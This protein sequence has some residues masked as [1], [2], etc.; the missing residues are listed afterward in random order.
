MLLSS[1]PWLLFVTFLQPWIKAFVIIITLS[2]SSAFGSYLSLLH[3]IFP[4]T[5]VTTFPLKKMQTDIVNFYVLWIKS[6]CMRI[7]YYCILVL[8]RFSNVFG[9]WFVDLVDGAL[10]CWWFEKL[11]VWKLHKPQGKFSNRY[12]L[13]CSN[14]Y[15]LQIAIIKQLIIV[16]HVFVSLH[17]LLQSAKCL[18][19]N[20][21]NVEQINS[22]TPLKLLMTLIQK[23]LF[24]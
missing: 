13:Y 11:N 6:C 18:L 1:C 12:I 2:L 16:L 14:I 22:K 3:T 24:S 23:Q 7:A 10:I 8:V 19:V 15:I 5:T 21:T 20:G 9:I 4:L 17:F